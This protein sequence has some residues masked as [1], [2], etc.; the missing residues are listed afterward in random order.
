MSTSTPQPD[1]SG[2]SNSPR[3]AHT[4]FTAFLAEQEAAAQRE[5]AARPAR[6]PRPAPNPP[7]TYYQAPP[8]DQPGGETYL[9]DPVL[10][11]RKALAPPHMVR[12]EAPADP[13]PPGYDYPPGNVY[14]PRRKHRGT[15]RKTVIN[16]D[17]IEDHDALLPPNRRGGEHWQKSR[18][19]R[20]AL[21]FGIVGFIVI[22]ALVVTF[23]P[24]EYLGIKREPVNSEPEN[25]MLSER[26]RP[27]SSMNSEEALAHSRTDRTRPETPARNAEDLTEEERQAVVR[28]ALREAEVSRK[29][30]EDELNQLKSEASGPAPVETTPSPRPSPTSPSI[31]VTPAPETGGSPL[32]VPPPPS[33]RPKSQAELDAEV[34]LL[35]QQNMEKMIREKK[36]Q[37][38]PPP[39]PP[40]TV[41]PSPEAVPAAPAPAAPRSARPVRPTP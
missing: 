11:P 38:T 27:N 39:P 30:V 40:S 24:D 18:G 25:P 23:L 15:A 35:M 34:N 36:L 21:I 37:A 41:V 26:A 12:P 7:P 3:E 33:T 16:E 8:T 10:E 19:R 1:P 13:M 29:K 4:D 17:V 6:T 5:A 22:A 9:D 32:D 28:E 31:S 2:S 20:D 14:P